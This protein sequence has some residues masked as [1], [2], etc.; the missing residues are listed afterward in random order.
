MTTLTTAPAGVVYG[1]SDDVYH[2]DPIPG[3]SLSSTGARRILESPALF[4]HEQQNRTG[5]RVFDVGHAVHSEVLGAGSPLIPY[6]AEHLTPSGAPSTKAASV[7]WVNEQRAA[8]LVPVAEADLLRVRAMTA[9]VLDNADARALVEVAGQP[10]ASVFVPDP[11]TGAW[12]RA[13]PD[14]LPDDPDGTIADLKTSRTANPAEFPRLAWRYHYEQQDDLYR[15]AVQLARGG[16]PRFVFVVVESDA[17]HLV[18]V[19]ELDVIARGIGKDR[20]DRAIRT[21]AECKASGVWPGY[22]PGIHTVPLPR[23]AETQHE[24]DYYPDLEV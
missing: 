20:N 21:Y 3:G 9:A 22:P 4:R 11:D 10:E 16:D 8:G 24:D 1:M 5:K 15:R 2:A 14:Y 13:R 17:P 6:P 23:Y 18:S 12:L 19:I 7:A